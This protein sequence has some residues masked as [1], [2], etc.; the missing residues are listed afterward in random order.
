[1]RTAMLTAFAVFLTAS[2][3]LAGG[4]HA[5]GHGDEAAMAIGHPAGD[6]K[7]LRTINLVMKD[8][9][10]GGMVFEPSTIAVRKGETIRLKF[11]NKGQQDHEFVMD[12]HENILEHKELMAKFPEM[13]HDDPNA[14]RLAA[15]Q[16]GEIVWTFA[17]AGEFSFACLIP[18]HYESGMKGALKVAAK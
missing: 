8:K 13:E 1:M 3:A 11:L 7:P 15:D 16:R 12:T 2:T 6:A 18:G 4:K 17:N 9:A 10:D 5:G 14:V